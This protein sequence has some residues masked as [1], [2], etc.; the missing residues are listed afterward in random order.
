M[1]TALVDGRF[2]LSIW[3]NLRLMPLCSMI[4]GS[5]LLLSALCIGL[6][7]LATS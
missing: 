4:F 5:I 1:K 3:Q 6:A 7:Y 2:K